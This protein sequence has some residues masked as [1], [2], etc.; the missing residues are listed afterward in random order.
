MFSIIDQVVLLLGSAAVGY[1]LA[2]NKYSPPR[3][4]DISLD[5]LK[6]AGLIDDDVYVSIIRHVKES[7]R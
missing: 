7:D 3:R 2:M 1:L 4:R 5:D 6:E